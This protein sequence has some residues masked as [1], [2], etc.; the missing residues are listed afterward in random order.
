MAEALDTMDMDGMLAATAGIPDMPLEYTADGWCVL[1]RDRDTGREVHMLDDG[2]K[3]HI[4]E[5]VPTDQ[6]VAENAAMRAENAGKRHGDGMSLVARVPLN[7]FHN[8]L[9]EA[10]RQGDD[11]FLRRWLND[12][13]HAAFRTRDGRI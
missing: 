9:G 1:Q 12:P 13:D 2:D 8:R 7:V 6:L 11:A 4:R 10:L 5:M 3:M